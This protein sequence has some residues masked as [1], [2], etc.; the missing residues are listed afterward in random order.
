[1]KSNTEEKISLQLARGQKHFFEEATNHKESLS[2]SDFIRKTTRR[3]GD[4]ILPDDLTILASKADQDI[5]FREITA[6]REANQNL[7]KAASRYNQQ[8]KLRSVDEKNLT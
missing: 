3:K 6:P 8:L 5:F 1:M 4:S 7:R 2:Q